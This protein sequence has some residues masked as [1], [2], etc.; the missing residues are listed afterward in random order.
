MNV[1]KAHVKRQF[2]RSAPQ[3]DGVST[4]QRD[5]VDVLLSEIPS[6]HINDLCD[7]GCGTG[8]ALSRLRKIYPTAR[9]IGVD[10]AAAMLK[11]TAHRLGDDKSLLIQGD[12]ENLPFMPQSVDLCL[13]SSAIQWCD[14]DRAIG[15]ISNVLR[16][17]GYTLI[18]SFLTGTL[19]DWR[20]LW[21]RNDQNFLSLR[22]LKRVI[23][24]SGLVLERIWCEPRIQSFNS[25]EHA[26][27]SVRSLGAGNASN[28]RAKGLMGRA[29]LQRVIEQVDSIIQSNGSIDMRYEVVYA[30]AYK[31]A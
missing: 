6:V 16:P 15:Q 22:E 9:V 13:S 23:S 30:K 1:N 3:Y 12:I 31:Q 7:L 10:M 28:H 17:G 4:M 5:I 8:Y 11:E 21:G 29:T 19:R 18:S 14:A 27:N 26:L 20:E 2:N 25:F 24:S